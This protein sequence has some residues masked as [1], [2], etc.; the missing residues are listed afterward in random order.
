MDKAILTQLANIERRTGKTL[1]ELTAIIT[2]S[3]LQ[4]HGELRDMLKRDMGMGHGDANLLVHLALQ[5]D[6]A[7]AAEAAGKSASDV[8]DD[9][10][11]GPKGPL[12]PVHDKVMAAIRAFGDLEESPKKTYVSLRRKKQF[13]TVGPATN[14]RVEVGLNMKGVPATAR[15]VEEPPGRMCQYKVKLTSADEVDADLVGWLRQA[16]D[17]AG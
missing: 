3:G 17:Q 10:Y 16:Y 5:T 7:S 12:R 2:G 15:L 8:V 14:T 13:A 1:D 9:I 11:A 6:A 4:K